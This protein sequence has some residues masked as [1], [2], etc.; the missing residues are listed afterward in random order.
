MCKPQ[1][2]HV[3]EGFNTCCFAYGQ[4]SSGKTYSIFG[5]DDEIRGILPR[6]AEYLFQSLSKKSHSTEY[7]VLCSFLEIYNDQ[8][9]DLGKAYLV[10]IGAE[11]STSTAQLKTSAISEHLAKNRLNTYIAPAFYNTESMG[12]GY[13]EVQD[14]Y[15]TMN[16][17]IREDGE[18]QV[19]VKNLSMVA[20][21]TIEEVIAMIN[22]GLKVRATHE[23]KMNMTSSRSHTVFTLAVSQKNKTSG[24]IIKGMLNIVDLAGSER[25]KKSESEGIRLKEALHINT[26]LSALGKVIMSLDPSVESTHI[27]YRDAKLTRIL[28]NSLGGNSYTIVLAALHPST[29]YYEE[30]L[31]TLQFA[32][33]CRNVKNNPK[34]NYGDESQADKD[35]RIKKLLEEVSTLRIKLNQSEKGLGGTGGKGGGALSPSRLVEVLK[36]MGLSATIASDGAL[37]VNGERHEADALGLEG[38]DDDS[39]DEEGRLSG[40]HGMAYEHGGEKT[41]KNKL[42][43]TCREL[44]DANKSHSIKSK[45]RKLVMQEQGKQI[46]DLSREVHL[47][48]FMNIYT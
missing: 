7:T 21:T 15:R 23:T 11:I 27:P 34:V 16:L 2:E 45:E 25:L 24:E 26:S 12:L 3:L 38:S 18:G 20:V 28:Q 1:V 33:R 40:E 19:F 6:S 31:S 44:Q 36:R 37:I 10:S 47:H 13:K 41:S 22:T 42:K 14:E 30:C 39:G 17:E 35:L 4:T 48:Q 43:R 46:Q 9:R 5:H 29:S 8:I 32:N